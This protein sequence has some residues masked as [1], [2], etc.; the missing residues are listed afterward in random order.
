MS[1]HLLVATGN[2]V[3]APARLSLDLLIIVHCTAR[4]HFLL[5]LTWQANCALHGEN[6][7][8]ITESPW[9]IETARSVDSVKLWN[10]LG[11]KCHDVVCKCNTEL[12]KT[13]SYT[14]CQSHPVS[15]LTHLVPPLGCVQRLHTACPIVLEQCPRSLHLL[16]WA[17]SNIFVYSNLSL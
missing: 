12:C 14:W 8:V 11:L 3:T 4:M 13:A 9:S 15:W 1:Q 5:W 17:C 7:V 6:A 16:L 10:H 2:Q